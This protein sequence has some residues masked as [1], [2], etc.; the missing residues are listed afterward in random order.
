MTDIRGSVSR[1]AGA[2]R[3]IGLTLASVLLAVAA[4]LT[5]IGAFGGP[6]AAAGLPPVQ[7]IPGEEGP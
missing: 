5:S 3:T 4:L 7:A 6:E 2:N 1:L